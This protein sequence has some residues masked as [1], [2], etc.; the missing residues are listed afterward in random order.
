M[1]ELHGLLSSCLA[2]LLC[3]SPLA[4][5]KGETIMLVPLLI[6]STFRIRSLD[7]FKAM[8]NVV[9]NE[10]IVSFMLHTRVSV[11]RILIHFEKYI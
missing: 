11:A 1:F 3:R 10:T 2:K 5:S 9:P 6:L 4:V 8:G 7:E